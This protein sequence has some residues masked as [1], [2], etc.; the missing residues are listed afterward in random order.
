MIIAE[1][2]I[3]KEI[4]QIFSL[5]SDIASIIVFLVAFM[6]VLLIGEISAKILGVRFNDSV[7]LTVAPIY[8][9]LVWLLLPLTVVVEWFVRGLTWIAGGK[10][11]MNRSAMTEE[12][13]DAFIDMSRDTGAVEATEHR[14][15]RWVLDLN[16]T[17]AESVM[18][19]RTQVEFASLDMT[20]KEVCSA[21][22]Q[23]SHSRLPVRGLDTDDV[24]YIITFRDAFREN[25]LGKST[26]KL[27]EMKLD[28]IINIP[29]TQMLD[30]VFITF[31]RS[32]RH[33]A[34]VVDEH[35]GTAGIITLEDVI[36]EV[37]G[38][39]KDEKDR[40]EVYIQKISENELIALWSTLIE[41]IFE[42]FSLSEMDF[43]IDES[44]IG[45][46]LSYIIMAE[47]EW[48]PEEG[49]HVV[50]RSDAYTLTLE[51]VSMGSKVVQKVSIRLTDSHKE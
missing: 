50:F 10:L 42:E 17:T 4:A 26:K 9:V 15:I 13:L 5:Q 8:Q 36:E 31:Q 30:D 23:S 24:K 14:Q 51:V 32:R 11:E 33:L 2:Y 46:N 48:F 3:T 40:E 38:D 20:I 37:F 21:F 49:K 39:I 19:P 41:D 18:T 43:N 47:L 16:E 25:A 35:G 28:K 27:S 7:A 22:L 6:I 34:R 1:K 29:L 44:Y 12:E 45:K